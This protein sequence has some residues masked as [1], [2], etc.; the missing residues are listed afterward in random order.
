ME[1]INFLS[2]WKMKTFRL[3]GLIYLFIL[4]LL[5]N[6]IVS[7][8]STEN[9]NLFQ[10]EM[11][12]IEQNRVTLDKNIKP[13]EDPKKLADKWKKPWHDDLPREMENAEDVVFKSEHDSPTIGTSNSCS[14][15]LSAVRFAYDNHLSLRISPDMFWITIINSIG[16]H[17]NK[18]AEKYRHVFVEHDG[19]KTLIAVY[20]PQSPI[21]WQSMVDQL[22]AQ[23]VGDSKSDLA[24]LVSL[25]HF[26]TT[27]AISLTV[28]KAG[29]MSAMQSYYEYRMEPMCG[30]HELIMMGTL[31]DWQRLRDVVSQMAKIPLDLDKYFKRIDVILA[32]FVRT[33]VG[34]VDV[35]FWS[36]IF[37]T[38]HYGSGSCTWNGWINHF[39][40]Y[41][42]DSHI[43]EDGGIDSGA[44]PPSYTITP[45]EFVT[46]ND[47][48]K[49]RQ[50]ISGMLSIGMYPDHSVGPIIQ[51]AIVED[52]GLPEK[53][54]FFF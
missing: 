51:Y 6:K 48:T 12:A 49:K 54:D 50:L 16:V 3:I 32:Q 29:L 14:A 42:G 35:G 38:K 19:K 4:F 17:I 9:K 43:I 13:C 10:Q 22:T 24:K 26:T 27:D 52:R 2:D 39:Y 8:T 53:P 47:E 30:I 40:V 1:D 33:Y 20:D 7:S 31:E 34:D 25:P 18:N 36:R 45:F 46:P 23:I 11:A 5:N 41:D 44:L 37:S 21:N 15:L 28:E